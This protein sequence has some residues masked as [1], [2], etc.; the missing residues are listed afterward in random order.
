MLPW[1]PNKMAI[2][3][4]TQKL[5]RQSSNDHNCQICFTLL[6]TSQVMKKMQFNHFSIKGLW[7]ISVAMATKPRDKSP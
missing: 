2:G 7:E 1:K 5:G 6:H 3:H 4:E